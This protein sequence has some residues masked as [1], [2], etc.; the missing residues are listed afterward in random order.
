[1]QIEVSQIP[2]GVRFIA[3]ALSGKGY[4]AWIVGGCVRDMLR[5]QAH[6]ISDWDL[7]TDA[8][9]EAV[10]SLFPKVVPTGLQHGTVTVMYEGVGYEVTT[11][12]GEGAYSDG[13]RPD[14]VFFVDDIEEDLARRDFTINAI[15][16]DPV[17]GTITDPFGGLADLQSHVIRAVGDPNERFSEDGLRVLRAARFAAVLQFSLEANTESAIRPNL[18]TFSKV[19]R[20]RVL[21]EWVK[22]IEKSERPSVAFEIMRHT[23]ILE[24]VGGPLGSLDHE[25][26]FHAMGRLNAAPREFP[27]AMAAMLLES[28]ATEKVI[29]GWLRSLKL[30]NSDRETIVK[31]VSSLRTA[32]SFEAMQGWTPAEV[33]RWASK[34][35]RRHL[36]DVS[37]VYLWNPF[38]G[39][40]YARAHVSVSLLSLVRSDVPLELK[41]LAVSGDVLQEHLGI[42]P[43]RQLG[44]VLKALLEFVLDDPARNQR[45]LLLAHARTLI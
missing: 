3:S 36:Q 17:D 24:L 30:S 27:S 7:T 18:E 43:S 21:A 15:A 23:G 26:F 40:T 32:P 13:R 5:G 45:E 37:T 31:I 39:S 42:G 34:I 16:A 12:R 6:R 9:P 25:R 35:G 44:E 33:R 20:E 22:A 4:K 8:K 38:G 10:M 28:E 11:L 19:A 1:M 29:D 41:G 2:E 14:E